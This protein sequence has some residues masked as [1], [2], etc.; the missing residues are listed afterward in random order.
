MLLTAS[1]VLPDM[2]IKR[3][4]LFGTGVDFTLEL[5]FNST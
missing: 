1:S 5:D 3:G 2:V 4:R